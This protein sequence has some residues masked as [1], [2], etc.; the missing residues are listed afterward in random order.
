ML[1]IAQINTTYHILSTTH[2]FNDMDAAHSNSNMTIE[3][4][5]TPLLGLHTRLVVLDTTITTTPSPTTPD[6]DKLSTGSIIGIVVG[7]VIVLIGFVFTTIF[8][9]RRPKYA[10]VWS[11]ESPV[12]SL[13]KFVFA[14]R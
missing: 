1:S 7:T 6:D 9:N 13:V 8:L 5:G 14:D 3:F 12:G 4:N 11:D 10:P 2:S